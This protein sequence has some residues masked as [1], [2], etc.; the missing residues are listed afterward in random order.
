MW[1]YNIRH[2]ENDSF[3]FLSSQEVFPEPEMERKEKV[4]ILKKIFFFLFFSSTT[5]E[6]AEKYFVIP[7]L[8]IS[9]CCLR[10][11]NL[12]EFVT[13]VTCTCSR[14]IPYRRHDNDDDD[15]VNLNGNVLLLLLLLTSKFI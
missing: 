15:Y 7:V 14:E 13:S 5:A 1:V 3:S 2:R 8:I 11:G 4:L 12:L 6:I 9:P 10:Q